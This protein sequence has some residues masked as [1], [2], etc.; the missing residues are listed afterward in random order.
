M[1]LN[2]DCVRDILLCV[3]ENTGLR[4]SCCF[5]D[6]DPSDPEMDPDGT[7]TIPDYQINLQSKYDNDMIIYHVK[8]CTDAGLLSNVRY[9]E[10]N[11]L[12]VDDL[13]PHGHDFI[14]NIRSEQNHSWLKSALTKVGSDSIPIAMQLIADHIFSGK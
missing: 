5:I 14:S 11:M 4:Q 2:L 13:T 3:E 7:T 8:Y 1:R 12:F 10:N 6:I 9:I